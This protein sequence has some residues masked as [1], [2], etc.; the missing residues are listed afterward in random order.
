MSC[1]GIHRGTSTLLNITEQPVEMERQV[2]LRGLLTC[3]ISVKEG[4]LV[5]Q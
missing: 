5:C 2:L 3:S 1:L 4:H